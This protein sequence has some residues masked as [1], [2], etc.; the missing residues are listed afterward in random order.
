M[1]V[2]VAHSLYGGVNYNMSFATKVAMLNFFV[3]KRT[4][5]QSLSSFKAWFPS[6]ITAIVENCVSS[7]IVA[8]VVIQ[9]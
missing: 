2:R 8:I 3:E 6:A 1:L 7:A 9:S 5:M 4:M